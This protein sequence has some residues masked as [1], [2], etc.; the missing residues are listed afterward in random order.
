[1][2]RLLRNPTPYKSEQFHY[3]E[4]QLFTM[5]EEQDLENPCLVFHEW[6]Y[7]A[8]RRGGSTVSPSPSD[9]SVS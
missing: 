5:N 4:T 1:M 3:Y 6:L 7:M 8:K 2:C 9:Q